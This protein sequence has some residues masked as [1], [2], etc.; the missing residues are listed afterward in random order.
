MQPL[1]QIQAILKKHLEGELTEAEQQQ[2]QQWL[3]QSAA[4]QS[5]FDKINHPD[6]LPVQLEKMEAFDEDRVWQ[7]IERAAALAP[8]KQMPLWRRSMSWAA[9]ILLLIL[10]GAGYWIVTQK[11]DK[12][13]IAQTQHKTLDKQVLPGKEGAILTLADGRQV[14]LDSVKQGMLATQHSTK[15]MVQDGR[16]VYKDGTPYDESAAIPVSNTITTTKGRY[17]QLILP[18]GSGVW[19]N[20]ASSITYPVAFTGSSREVSITGEVYFEVAKDKSRPFR[21]TANEVQV[22]VLGTHFNIN[23]YTNE[24]N[25]SIT[26]L[27][28][29]VKVSGNKAKYQPL[30]LAPGQQARIGGQGLELVPKANIDEVMAWKNG[31]FSYQDADIQ[32]VMRQMERWYD[33]EVKFEGRIPADRFTGKV[34]RSANLSQVLRILKLSD[35]NI[36][37]DGKTLTIS[38]SGD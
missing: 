4:N 36:R 17:Y 14:L 8:V 25:T 34:P 7:R 21:V 24:S 19:L 29:S 35:V 13:T 10:A 32:T 6:Y 22:E 12:P 2:L 3:K 11:N 38:P 27:E 28:G 18:D 5:L 9:T 33:I 1:Q 26:L 15:L 37:M 30:I 31:T 23:G 20:A 16:L